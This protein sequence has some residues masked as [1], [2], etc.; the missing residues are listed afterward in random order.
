MK[1]CASH[2]KRQLLIAE[3]VGDTTA[4]HLSPWNVR[5]RCSR[6]PRAAISCWSVVDPRLPASAHNLLGF[7]YFWWRWTDY[8]RVDYV[9]LG[10]RMTYHVYFFSFPNGA[11]I[12]KSC[13]HFY[14]SCLYVCV[15]VCVSEWI[16]KMMLPQIPSYQRCLHKHSMNEWVDDDERRACVHMLWVWHIWDISGTAFGVVNH[17]QKAGVIKT[18]TPFIFGRTQFAVVAESN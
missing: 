2:S 5:A 16:R 18:E 6:L 1:Y 17:R 9:T 13:L 4:A 10:K 3:E 7:Y 8:T 12:K 15:C 11:P 14:S